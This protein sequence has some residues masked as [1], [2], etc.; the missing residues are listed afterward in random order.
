MSSRYERLL[1]LT[2]RTIAR[3]VEN[4]SGQIRVEDQQLEGP[5][6]TV[7]GQR[8]VDFGSC[9]YL[10]LNRSSEM[11][12]RAAD[13]LGRFGTAHS[14]SPMYT[15]IG[16]YSDLEQRLEEIFGS[17]VAVAPTT[18]LAHLAALPVLI[19]SS[20]LLLV[21]QFSHASLQLT[22]DV[23]R[24]RGVEVDF[25][26]HNDVAALKDRLHRD[27]SRYRK[28]WY[29][30]DG[31]YSMFGDVA[32]VEE[33]NSL[34]PDFENLH[35]YYD[36]AHGFGWAGLNGRGYVLDRVD[37]HPR[38]IVAA[39]LSKSFGATGGVL[40]FGDPALRRRVLYT[41]GPLTFAGPLQPADLGAAVASGDFHLSAE[42]A[43]Y[44]RRFY[45][46][47]K[48]AGSLL[49][50]FGLPIASDECT[51]IWFI[52]IG[53]LQ[54][55]LEIT[56]AVMDDGYYVNPASY[57]AVPMGSAGIRFTQTLH[58]TDAQLE[59]LIESLSR[60]VAERGGDIAVDL[61]S[62]IAALEIDRATVQRPS[63]T[64]LQSQSV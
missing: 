30:G 47:I 63:K 34:L 51:P 22:S 54:E 42:H 19:D 11:V 27:A 37:W 40:A 48:L 17:P 57:P 55:V 25:L 12:E 3:G 26:P 44:Q 7:D 31:V 58:Q 56:R 45:Q 43:E 28:V 6:I 49:K 20:D 61:R 8:I 41:G 18:T 62:R 5:Y 39:G 16:L 1:R 23:L 60:H 59:G 32:P 9:A 38:M 64:V 33:I 13:A 29:A 35:L 2:E 21:D 10:G 46:K 53:Q 50:D 4:R 36:D 52:V 24:G 15:A 14:S